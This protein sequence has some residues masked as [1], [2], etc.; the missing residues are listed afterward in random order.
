M[1]L[2]ACWSLILLVSSTWDEPFGAILV[3][4]AYILFFVIVTFLSFYE[5]L[6]IFKKVDSLIRNGGQGNI[7][8]K[9]NGFVYCSF[10]FVLPEAEHFFVVCFV[11]I[12]SPFI[13][14]EWGLAF[15]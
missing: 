11:F 6:S 2:A 13:H 15:G 9:I 1:Q 5:E 4:I 10:T 14:K 12:L 7:K 3:Y 8:L